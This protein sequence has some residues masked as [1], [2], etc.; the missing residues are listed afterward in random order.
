M[1]EGPS[2]F[3]NDGNIIYLTRSIDVSSKSKNRSNADSTFGIFISRKTKGNWSNPIGF[4]FNSPA[5]NTG[6]PS[7]TDDGT[8]LFFC[9]DAPGGLGGL[10]I[11]VSTLRGGSWGEPENLGANVNTSKNEVFPFLQKDGRLYFASRGL[12][13]Q[14]D[15]DIYYTIKSNGTWQKPVKL[16]SP[17][18]SASDDYGL[19]FNTKSDT[20]F[21]VSERNGSSDIFAAYSTIP[22]FVNCPLQ[23]KNDY[24]F[25]FYES[26]SKELDTTA[27]AYEW[28]LGDG[29]KIR[30]IEAEHCFA[31]PGDYVVELNVI[32]KITK[33]VMV[34]Q[35]TYNFKVENIEQP[36]IMGPDTV[37]T[38]N[39]ISFN[40]RD[41]YLKDMTIQNYYWDFGDGARL[42]G[43][44]ASHTY[45]FPGT[46]N[47]TLGVTGQS[48]SSSG[49]TT[50]S[51]CVTQQI[52]VGKNQK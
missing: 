10:D 48:N 18:N 16:E 3:S 24:C 12:N 47:I 2:C 52:V 34:S 7:V 31:Q 25:V 49:P 39:P 41:S 50:I 27:F 40:G 1:Y 33:E 8:Q 11:Y 17:F 26:N 22:V 35:A 42:Q 15:L 32:D 4:R 6:Y 13:Q 21:F 14:G 36:Y 19:I 44:E 30:A 43:I 20:A 46:Y 51:H 29:T 37:I 9:S 38:G 45:N 28:D 23:K 5:Y